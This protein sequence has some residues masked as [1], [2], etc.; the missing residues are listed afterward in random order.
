MVRV[1]S[2][3]EY[4]IYF[5][6]FDMA[7]GFWSWGFCYCHMGT[8]MGYTFPFYGTRIRVNGAKIFRDLYMR[9]MRLFL[10]DVIVFST[11][12]VPMQR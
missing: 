3:M 7:G 6:C 8:T 5:I 12:L 1:M 2:T 11:M 4:C 10:D 9:S